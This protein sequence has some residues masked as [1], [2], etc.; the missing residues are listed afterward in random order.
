M[1]NEHW[2]KEQIVNQMKLSFSQEIEIIFRVCTFYIYS[3]RYMSG[4]LGEFGRVW[5][6]RKKCFL[7]LLK[8]KRTVECFHVFHVFHTVIKTRLLANQSSRQVFI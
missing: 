8:N 3:Y 2:Y 6:H 4:N 1:E 7:F 5:E